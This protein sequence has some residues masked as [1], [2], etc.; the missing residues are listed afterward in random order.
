MTVVS[1]KPSLAILVCLFTSWERLC[2]FGLR[3]LAAFDE[4]RAEGPRTT[5]YPCRLVKAGHP[6]LCSPGGDGGKPFA[7]RPV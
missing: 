4:S 6:M 3:W 2:S 5:F 7:K 1:V